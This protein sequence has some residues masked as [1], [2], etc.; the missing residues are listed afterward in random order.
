MRPHLFLESPFHSTGY[1][2]LLEQRLKLFQK[3]LAQR[4]RPDWP[5]H[6]RLRR[7]PWVGWHIERTKLISRLI[8]ILQQIA[9]R[10]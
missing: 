4:I 6:G 5:F 8:A 3:G 7:G 9:D 1:V 2:A 10:C